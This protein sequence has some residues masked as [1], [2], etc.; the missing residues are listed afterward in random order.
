MT[1]HR[2]NAACAAALA[3]NG[4]GKDEPVPDETDRAKLGDG[5]SVARCGLGGWANLFNGPPSFPSFRGNVVFALRHWKVDSDLAGVRDP[6]ALAKLPAAER[7]DSARPSGPGSMG[8]PPGRGGQYAE[9][10]PI[11][12]GV[13]RPTRSPAEPEG[14][15]SRGKAT[16]QELPHP[17][18]PPA[19]SGKPDLCFGSPSGRPGSG[20]LANLPP[21]V[22]RSNLV[23]AQSVEV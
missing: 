3:A 7:K 21:V 15:A 1:Q 8:P 13:A 17:Q 2:Y 19:R 9:A 12:R 10:R 16:S 11:G 4:M 6:N 20:R 22:Q 5:L 14:R 18:H 23:M